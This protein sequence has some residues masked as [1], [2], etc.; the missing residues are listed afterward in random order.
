MAK[1]NIRHNKETVTCSSPSCGMAK[2]SS[3][4]SSVTASMSASET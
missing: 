3:V 4:G 1:S 2:L